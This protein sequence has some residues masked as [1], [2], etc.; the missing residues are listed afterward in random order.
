MDFRL[1]VLTPAAPAQGE[2]ATL[3]P[4][5]QPAV[6]LGGDPHYRMLSDAPHRPSAPKAASLLRGMKPQAQRE[7]DR[8]TWDPAQAPAPTE[9]WAGNRAGPGWDAGS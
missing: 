1:L 5:T 2:G 7:R 8:E 4:K 6:L 9:N 3:A